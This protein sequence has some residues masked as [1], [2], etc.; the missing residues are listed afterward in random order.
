[1]PQVA[2]AECVDVS[3]VMYKVMMVSRVFLSP[4]RSTNRASK[5][6]NA[7]AYRTHTVLIIARVYASTII[8]T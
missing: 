5:T 3:Q 1:M 6:R 2:S 7:R 4:L 8:T